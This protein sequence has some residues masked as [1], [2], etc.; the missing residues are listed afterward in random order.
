MKNDALKKH[1]FW[2]VGGVS[3]LLSLLV[4]VF[5]GADVDAAIEKKTSDIKGVKS[6]VDGA[7]APG[8][9]A[10]DAIEEEKKK[11]EKTR[12]DLW[13]ANWEAQKAFF[14]WP[15]TTERLFDSY[16][17]IKF[18]DAL[19]NFDDYK[20]DIFK[21][22]SVY[23]E[24]YEAMAKS[25]APTQFLG[26]WQAV[27][28]ER[29]VAQWQDK[30][31]EARQLWLAMEDVWVQR[32]LL[33]PIEQINTAAANFVRMQAEAAPLKQSF[34]TD[35]WKLDLEVVDQA[36]SKILKGKLRNLTKQMQLLGTG[37]AMTLKV[38][39]D[40]NLDLPPFEFKIE[41][42][43]VP[44][45]TEIVI[46]MMASHVIP[47][48]TAVTEIFQV[49]LVL[50]ER[51]V[52]IRQINTLSL[53]WLNSKDFRASAKE[54]TVPPEFWK[55]DPAAAGD[56]GVPGAPGAP[57]APGGAAGASPP[58]NPAAIL[59]AAAARGEGLS[60][61]GFGQPTGATGSASG[62]AANKTLTDAVDA[63]RKRYIE[64]TG[65][66]RR[67]PV[68]IQVV[69][70]QRVMQDV[71]VAYANSPLRLQI[72]Q[73]QFSRYRGPLAS[74]SATGSAV[75]A[76]AGPAGDVGPAVSGSIGDGLLSRRGETGRRALEG[77]VSP[78]PSTGDGAAPPANVR[79]GEYPPPSGIPGLVGG[80]LSS[81]SEAQANSSLVELQIYG[82]VTLYE[83]FDDKPAT[84]PGAIATAPLN[85]PAP[86]ASTVPDPAPVSPPP[87]TET[88]PA[89]I[90]PKPTLT[91]TPET[92]PKANTPKP[93]EPV[94]PNP[95]PVPA[96]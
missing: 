4:F 5:V 33:Q 63:Q 50:D 64:V 81:V 34:A 72:V 26:G 93:E 59:G 71:M 3:L 48:G 57:A 53:K 85:T 17:T 66:L 31:P 74:E 67:M 20:T 45:E 61:R 43:Y 13:K 87:M 95:N 76:G 78:A 24:L 36:P 1:H 49:R 28:G 75:A 69:C 7:R 42:E 91:P 32:A 12:S 55:D 46:P 10:L 65:Q 15:V 90:A 94:S 86:A 62:T 44:G 21:R 22:E 83:K 79:G 58:A 54:P 23:K 14:T 80:S 19:P 2:I 16:N 77:A 68:A 35:I 56:L 39:L 8:K 96:P 92:A 38:W 89:P 82:I 25:V 11:L 37:G 30:K 70:D 6:T 84:A 73:Y 41:G 40:K 88:T 9:V 18:G 51:T 47:L 29:F 52:P 27:L 60:P